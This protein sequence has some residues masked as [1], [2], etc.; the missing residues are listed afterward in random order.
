[1]KGGKKPLLTTQT[2]SMYS[3]GFLYLELL[4]LMDN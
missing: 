3:A 1:L 4:V 2:I